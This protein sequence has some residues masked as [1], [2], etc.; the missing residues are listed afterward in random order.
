VLVTLYK[1]CY[2]VGQNQLYEEVKTWILCSPRS[3]RHNVHVLRF[4]HKKWVQSVVT[5]SNLTTW[6][7]LAAE[8][9][10]AGTVK[11]ACLWI[12]SF[13]VPLSG[14]SKTSKK[15]PSWS[16]KLNLPGQRFMALLDARGQFRALWGGYSP[17]IYDG[18]FLKIQSQF[19][20]DKLQGAVIL[21][22]NHFSYSQ[23][24]FNGVKF[25]TTISRPRGRSASLEGAQTLT[26]EQ[27]THNRELAS[28]CAHVENSFGHV[29]G[30]FNA[31]RTAWHEDESQHNAAVWTAVGIANKHL[32]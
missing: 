31:L 17:K 2:A 8:L 7:R 24:A 12:D 27:E 16:Y 10:L 5:L 25:I 14:V 1:D 32:Q 18:D 15:D 6:R 30:I 13:D 29:V 21:A 22:D 19:I 23:T 28:A 4:V 11:G 26:Q 9:N 3:L 20:E